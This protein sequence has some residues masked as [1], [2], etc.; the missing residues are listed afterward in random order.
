MS[1]NPVIVE[2]GGAIFR[3]VARHEV[4]ATRAAVIRTKPFEMVGIA[5]MEAKE[6]GLDWR[7]FGGRRA[8]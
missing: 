1:T 2:E 8:E 6:S 5:A 4:L 7:G 3:E